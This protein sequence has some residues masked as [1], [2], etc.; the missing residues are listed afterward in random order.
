MRIFIFVI[1]FVFVGCG[2]E[3]S[4]TTS[5]IHPQDPS[6]CLSCDV[7]LPSLPPIS[8]TK[9]AVKV[10]PLELSFFCVAGA[11][12]ESVQFITIYNFTQ[13]VIWIYQPTIMSVRNDDL[14]GDASHFN[15]VDCGEFPV[16]L[17]SEERLAVSV[18][19]DWALNTQVGVLQIT[20]DN[21][22]FNV[23]LIGKLYVY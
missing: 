5:I 16:S 2:A 17:K 23:D 15:L 13:S 1:V 6:K 18:L 22:I 7:N 11:K 20:A 12:C 9:K 19:F 8:E 3:N 21:V 4:S 10:D 14:Y